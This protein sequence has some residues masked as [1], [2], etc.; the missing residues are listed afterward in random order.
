LPRLREIPADCKRH[1]MTADMN[2]PRISQINVLF[3]TDGD[4][5][6]KYWLPN[7]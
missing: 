4:N 3:K 6:K 1:G 5:V 2:D 7:G